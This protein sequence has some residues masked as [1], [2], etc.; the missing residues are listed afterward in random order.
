MKTLSKL[1]IFLVFIIPLNGFGQAGDDVYYSPKKDT[2][3]RVAPVQEE[4]KADNQNQSSE[5]NSNDDVPGYFSSETHVDEDGDTYINNNYYDDYYDYAYASRIRRFYSGCNNYGY[6]HDY[7]TNQYWYNYDPFS[8][9]VSIYLGYNWWYPSYYSWYPSFSFSFPGFSFNNGGYYGCSNYYFSYYSGYP[10]WGGSYYDGYYNGYWN[11]FNDG[12]YY[13]TA[14]YYY[15]SYD[16]NSS[17]GYNGHRGSVVSNSGLA[18][19]R[20]LGDIYESSKMDHNNN[21]IKDNVIQKRVEYTDVNR[22]DVKKFSDAKSIENPRKEF[23]LGA[24]SSEPVKKDD[25][26]VDRFDFEP[27]KETGREI[28]S[29]QANPGSERSTSVAPHYNEEPTPSNEREFNDKYDYYTPGNEEN[30]FRSPVQKESE[31]QNSRPD[32]KIESPKHD[33]NERSNAFSEPK[34]N[35]GNHHKYETPEK[36]YSPK[37]NR[38]SE[39]PSQPR[40]IENHYSAPKGHSDK[41]NMSSP[42]SNN[43]IS[44]PSKSFSQPSHNSSGGGR[45]SGN[46]HSQPN[47]GIS[48]GGRTR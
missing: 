21:L 42:G 39:I 9:G 20:N 32:Y 25:R 37:P 23:D 44:Q 30:I 28:N 3:R 40:S 36:N 31:H 26:S 14:N 18:A 48:K 24:R 45:S 17:G 8:W 34:N 5:F 33:V 41:G 22:I 38:G 43:H 15:N 46:N 4:E 6:Y 10:Y 35:S 27:K 16:R 12:S 47:S 19:P 29:I 1:S 2:L 11:G 7:Y 13:S